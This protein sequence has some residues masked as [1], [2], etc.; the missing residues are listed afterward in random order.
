MAR[1]RFFAT[2][3]YPYHVSVRSNSQEWF[4]LPMDEVWNIF[5]RYLYFVTLAYGLRI[6]S[7]VLMNNHFHM[8]VTTPEANLDK[9]MEYLL[10]ET[11]KMIGRETDRIHKIFESQY[12]KSLIRSRLHYSHAYKYVYRNPV[13]A[14]ICKKVED[15]PYSTLRGL[16]GVEQLV[17]P[18]FDN[19]DLI[20][21]AGK[22]L[23][24]LNT[25][26]PDPDFWESIRLALRHHEFEFCADPISRK[27]T[28]L[29]TQLF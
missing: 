10:R 1:K 20:V 14:G 28:P 5:S 22:Q 2:N 17:I 18:T 23:N 7:F 27:M 13:E 15:Y 24:W 4:T 21:N 12:H 3:Q 19:M 6:H 8:L 25:P 11:S 26:Y 16:L 29:Q 9:A